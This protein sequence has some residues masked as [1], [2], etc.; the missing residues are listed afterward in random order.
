MKYLSVTLNPS[1]HPK[2]TIPQKQPAP[3]LTFKNHGNN[4]KTET[5]SMKGPI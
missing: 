4:I 2:T 3:R 5:S 1:D